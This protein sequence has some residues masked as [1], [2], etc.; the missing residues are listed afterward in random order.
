MNINANTC[1]YYAYK[2]PGNKQVPATQILEYLDA[3]TPAWTR[4]NATMDQGSGHAIVNTLAQIYKLAPKVLKRN[5]GAMRFHCLQIILLVRV[6]SSWEFAH[7]SPH[8]ARSQHVRE[9]ARDAVF[10]RLIVLSGV[11]LDSVLGQC[12][13]LAYKTY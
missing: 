5:C 11:P 2:L 13:T 7:T 1:R 9:P 6:C 4:V 10:Y 12:L 8:H 3:Q